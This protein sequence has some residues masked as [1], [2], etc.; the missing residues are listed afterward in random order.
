MLGSLT[1]GEKLLGILILLCACF[2]RFYGLNS[3]DL[4]VDEYY[5][6]TSSLSI[7]ENGIPN[8]PDGGYYTRGL[9]LQYLIAPIYL[10]TGDIELSVRLIPALSGILSL[11]AVFFITQRLTNNKAALAAAALYALSLWEIEFARFGRM[12]TPFQAVFLW[13]CYC[14]IAHFQSRSAESLLAAVSLGL[15]S[16]VVYEGAIF[17][18]LTSMF[19]LFI[20]PVS[21]RNLKLS[22][23]ILLGLATA[24]LMNRINLRNTA[25]TTQP[26]DTSSQ[27]KSLPINLPELIPVEFS[28]GTLQLGL[29]GT[30][31]IA[32]A[33]IIKLNWSTIWTNVN[34][35]MVGA[36]TVLMIAVL[37]TNQLVFGALLCLIVLLLHKPPANNHWLR[38][39]LGPY[40]QLFF[41]W[42]LAWCSI[43]LLTP[44]LSGK[45]F[46]ATISA[47]P[48]VLQAFIWPWQAAMPT[49]GSIMILA[50]AALSV[51]IL[52]YG[53]E[54]TAQASLKI[55]M[56]LFWL[57]IVATC[58]M[59]TK[60]HLSRYTYYLHP[61]TLIALVT[62]TYL[63]S[64]MTRNLFAGTAIL[65]APLAGVA[66]ISEN[67]HTEHLLN[68]SSEQYNYRKP[69]DIHRQMHFYIR[70]DHRTVAEFVNNNALP[71]DKVFT[72][73]RVVDH[74]LDKVDFTY[75]PIDMQAGLQAC[76][77]ACYIWNATPLISTQ[78]EVEAL[79][80]DTKN[81][82]WVITYLSRNQFRT[83]LDEHIE[84]NYSDRMVYQNLDGS[85]GVFKF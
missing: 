29:I 34:N 12:Y 50:T 47:T 51:T 16:I 39:L 15:L 71:H 38:S 49:Q 27:A 21:L 53:Q 14:V 64:Q 85:I 4:S 32:T 18:L 65:L 56:A 28:L 42:A 66:A 36:L 55:L 75:I 8:F 37:M 80:E 63:A 25:T 58:I 77:G 81:D 54:N 67:Y 45:E 11:L 19:A 48:K 26:I 73:V 7:A 59:D 20:H 10:I 70:F 41:V 3:W 43:M 69:Y 22:L 82:L 1:Q 74:Y 79:L 44:S 31:V 68:I 76:G 78:A 40:S 46:L 72:S 2:L 57:L 84:S 24:F 30:A 52:I 17:S 5:L 6:A 60:Y 62:L 33:I 13:Q 35:L 83:N 9:L 61:L 23:I